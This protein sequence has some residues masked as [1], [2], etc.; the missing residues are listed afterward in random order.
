MLDRRWLLPLLL[1]AL[2]PGNSPAQQV[3]TAAQHVPPPDGTWTLD[4]VVDRASTVTDPDLGAGQGVA[5]RDGKLYAYGDVWGAN[6]RTGVIREY[7][8]DLKP[9]GR[10]VWLR[11]GGKPLILHPTGL[12]WDAR[13]GTF[14][15]DTVNKKATIYRLDWERA[16]LDGNLDAAVLGAVE[17]DA[18]VNGCRPE[19][20]RVGGRTLLATADYGDVRP[21]IRL[22][23]PEALLKAGRTSAPG[24]VVHR[25]LAGAW[26]QNLSW[27]PET[28]RLV[29]VENVIEGRGWRLDTLDLEKAVADGRADGPGVRVGRVTF[30][31]H[32]ELEGY[33]RLDRSRVLF[34]TSSR[35]GNLVAGVI[36]PTEPRPSPPPAKP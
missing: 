31:P 26:N 14:L 15:G 29:C 33:C 3:P 35:S 18:A 9:T 17:D 36:R 1:V 2:S 25:V 8:L 6:P 24:V 11:K 22:L 32:D 20:V 34:I 19:F 30:E 27:D 13:F 10:A 12:T 7:D 4:A 21:E 23:D 5:V 16:W 28:G